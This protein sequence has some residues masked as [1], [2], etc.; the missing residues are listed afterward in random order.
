LYWE[1]LITIDFKKTSKIYSVLIIIGA[2]IG[3]LAVFL[4]WV[5]LGPSGTMTGLELS[6]ETLTDPKVYSSYITWLPL[7]VLIASLNAA[8]NGAVSATRSGRGGGS[9]AAVTGVILTVTAVL[10]ITDPFNS[11]SG[12]TDFVSIGAYLAVAAGV[13]VTIFGVLREIAK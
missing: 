9:S 1:W 7:V 6:I 5:E 3:I 8:I 10:F 12:M 4:T 2:L 11:G 13:L